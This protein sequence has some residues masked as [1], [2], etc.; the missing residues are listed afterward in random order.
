VLAICTRRNRVEC[1]VTATAAVAVEGQARP[2]RVGSS[3]RARMLL[4]VVVRRVAFGVP[5]VLVVTML[6]FVLVS[7]T[8]GDPAREL[9]GSDASPAMVESVRAELGLDRSLVEQYTNW[10]G[11]AVQ[12]DLGSS[13][14][15]GEDVRTAISTRMPVT[16]SLVLLG[17]MLSLILGVALGVFSAV[18]GGAV[19]KILDGLTLVG[20]ALPSIWV[21]AILIGLFS[22]KLGWF[23]ATGYSPIEGGLG[24]WARSLALPVSALALHAVAAIA[25]Q[26]REAMLD[27][28]GSEYIRMARANGVRAGSLIFRHALKNAGIRVVTVLGLLTIGLLGGT[29]LVES[30]FALPG[31]GGTSV[32]ASRRHDLPV[33]QGIVAIFTVLVVVVNLLIDVAYSLLNPKVSAR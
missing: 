32:E 19:A 3:G 4:G 14:Y 28:L 27:V 30:V 10:L 23:P 13:I 2:T 5:L 20:F 22:V 9:L 17:V 6:S 15:T 29:V 25:K 24:G 1:V 33:I 26:T 11:A 7:F 12:G 21:G 8:P 18:R 31:L 16:I